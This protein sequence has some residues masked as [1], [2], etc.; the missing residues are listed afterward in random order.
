LQTHSFPTRRS[1]DLPNAHVLDTMEVKFWNRWLFEQP[2]K[3]GW[4]FKWMIDTYK[5]GFN[6]ITNYVLADTLSVRSL[7]THLKKGHL[8]TAFKS[9]GDA[10]GFMYYAT[11]QND[12]ICGILGDSITLEQ[13]KSLNA[14]SPLPGQFSLVHDGK[15]INISSGSL[16]QYS[17]SDL[18]ERGAYRIE[19]HL[20]LNGMYVPWIYSNPIYIY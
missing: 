4:V 17:W 16:Y 5:E 10:S 3:N 7:A 15:T 18:I 11:N 6:Y 19:V 8:Y 12:S 20:Q 9:L 1:S 13:V 14:V 2:D